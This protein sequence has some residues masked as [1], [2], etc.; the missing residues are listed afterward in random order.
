MSKRTAFSLGVLFAM[1]RTIM[2]I[3][4]PHKQEWLAL[5]EPLARALVDDMDV[6]ALESPDSVDLRIAEANE[7]AKRA[8]ESNYP[9][10]KTDLPR[11]KIEA[12]AALNNVWPA[13]FYK[14]LLGFQTPETLSIAEAMATKIATDVNKLKAGDEAIAK[15]ARKDNLRFLWIP[16]L[17]V[18]VAVVKDD[19]RRGQPPT[20]TTTTPTTTTTTLSL[21]QRLFINIFDAY[22]DSN[23]G[24][25]P[26]H[27]DMTFARPRI[28]C[29]CNEC[30][31][32][33]DFLSDGTKQVFRRQLTKPQRYH[34]H[35]RLDAHGIDCQHETERH[36][37][38]ETLVI[39]KTTTKSQKVVD[40]W[41]SNKR[42]A[43]DKIKEFP[44]QALKV[45]LGPEYERIVTMEKLYP[46]GKAPEL[47]KPKPR[48]KAAAP[49]A[50][51]AAA[52]R[53]ADPAP[54]A[55]ATTP[56]TS[57]TL[58]DLK[59]PLPSRERKRRALTQSIDLT[60]LSDD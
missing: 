11:L 7:K 6:P 8:R 29:I 32:V 33:N 23:V 26:D 9:V 43:Q 35:Q 10:N 59:S 51:T 38:P 46:P 36:T 2:A 31:H 30:Y 20:S 48:G 17:R 54:P 42:F 15:Q 52:A 27:A 13:A 41:N 40:A 25:S 14:H 56:P 49:A 39:T 47:P 28:P 18:L 60:S 53:P 45:L 4:V 21:H 58:P 50:S 55:R 44:V 3:P 22:L 1:A 34:I 24:P 5:Y 19:V 12:L 37:Y 16:F 57:L